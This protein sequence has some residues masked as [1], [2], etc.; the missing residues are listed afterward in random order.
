MKEFVDSFS[1]EY[2]AYLKNP[3]LEIAKN[4]PKTRMEAII[5]FPSS[6]MFNGKILKMVT[7]C[8]IS[9]LN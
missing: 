6:Q 3:T 1:K 5:Y 2:F 4:V 7:T 8:L 9:S